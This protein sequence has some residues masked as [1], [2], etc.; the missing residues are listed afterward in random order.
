MNKRLNSLHLRIPKLKLDGILFNHS[1]ILPSLNVRYLSGFTGSDALLLVTKNER[2]MITD[3]R[4]SIQASE[5]CPDFSLHIDR[6]KLEVLSKLGTSLGIRRLGIE[7][8]R[9]S[10][11]FVLQLQKK[12]PEMQLVPLNRD[13]V[14]NFRIVKNDEEIELIRKAAQIASKACKHTVVKGL[15]GRREIDVALELE[16][17]FFKFGADGVAFETIVASGPRSALPHGAPTE[18]RIREGDLVILDYGCTVKGY[19]SDETI[20]ILRTRQTPEQ[21]KIYDAVLEA[22]NRALESAKVGVGLKELDAIARNSIAQAGFGKYFNHGL[23]HGLGLETHEPPSVSPK[24]RGKLLPGMIITIEPGIYVENVGGVR[25]ESLVLIT[26]SGPEVL[27][28]LPKKLF[29]L[30]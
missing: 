13:F 29:G 7:A 5:E 28:K 20:T 2:H 11:Q 3:G 1:E 18:R 8:N 9:I 14:E 19:R 30:L 21:R 25:L 24:G 12:C 10:H 17:F 6:N 22:H 23:G 15:T 27:S 4:Y 26:D 16:S